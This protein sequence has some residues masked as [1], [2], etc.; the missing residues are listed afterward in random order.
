MEVCTV[1]VSLK[2]TR[3]ERGDPQTTAV[4]SPSDYLKA[5]GTALSD[6]E[7]SM[8]NYIT[9]ATPSPNGQ[10][11]AICSGLPDHVLILSVVSPGLIR[12]CNRAHLSLGP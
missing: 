8:S 3:V 5:A 6:A 4:L 2:L 10:W 7:M 1:F 11:M 9:M 12:H